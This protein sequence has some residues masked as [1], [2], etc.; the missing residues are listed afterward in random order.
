M[1]H[2]NKKI[3]VF[4]FS[5]VWVRRLLFANKPV[6]N[7]SQEG[8]DVLKNLLAKIEEISK[9]QN[10]DD[11]TKNQI[12]EIQWAIE[13]IKQG[14]A[15][16]NLLS[17]LKKFQKTLD[18]I[19]KANGKP[20]NQKKALK[21]LIHGIHQ[22][23]EKILGENLKKNIINN[24]M[25]ET[26]GQTFRDFWLDGQEWSSDLYVK[27][28]ELNDLLNKDEW[29]GLGEAVS[30]TPSDYQDVN[31]NLISDTELDVVLDELLNSPDSSQWTEP[32]PESKEENPILSW[33][34]EDLEKAKNNKMIFIIQAGKHLGMRIFISEIDDGQIFVKQEGWDEEGSSSLDEFKNFARDIDLKICDQ[35]AGESEQMNMMAEKVWEILVNL[36]K[37]DQRLLRAIIGE[38]M[39]TRS[40]KD[41]SLILK[42]LGENEQK[43]FYENVSITQ[44]DLLPEELEKIWPLV[45]IIEVLPVLKQFLEIFE[46]KKKEAEERAQEEEKRKK[47]EEAR[48]KAEEA[49]KAKEQ[50]AKESQTVKSEVKKTTEKEKQKPEKAERTPKFSKED[51]ENTEM[52]KTLQGIEIKRS[53]EKDLAHYEKLL[54]SGSKLYSKEK[55][56]EKITSIKESIKAVSKKYNLSPESSENAEVK[57]K[58]QKD[59]KSFFT[60]FFKLK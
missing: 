17:E 50:A 48:K 3:G 14:T 20:E 5:L 11:E 58:K 33:T 42:V 6:E 51:L 56:Q 18:I 9:K 16:S 13:K 29:S 26:S 59:K 4:E 60:K 39:S 53:L 19:E 55:F 45:S 54:Q 27:Q 1:F 22:A 2:L 23:I 24:N 38:F 41:R 34:L 21:S 35:N 25:V 57:W 49:K 37:S 46:A 28:R 8:N 36:N 47:E 32:A 12:K 44:K 15:E 7:T 40:E 31:Q 52:H 43:I 10:L 30:S